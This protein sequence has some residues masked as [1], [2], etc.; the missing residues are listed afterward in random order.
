MVADQVELNST[1]RDRAVINGTTAYLSVVEQHLQPCRQQHRQT[2]AN[3]KVVIVD[4]M[5]VD[6]WITFGPLFGRVVEVDGI[7]HIRAVQI[8]RR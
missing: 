5:A 3:G 8:A 1:H 7:P 4:K 6:V 2:V